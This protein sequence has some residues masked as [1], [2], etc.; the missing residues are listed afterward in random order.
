LGRLY[1][2]FKS[3]AED[4]K[5]TVEKEIVEEDASSQEKSKSE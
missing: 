5:S 2:Q 1:R 3:A 4:L